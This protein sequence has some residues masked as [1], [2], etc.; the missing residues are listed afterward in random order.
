MYTGPASPRPGPGAGG[1]AA[2]MLRCACGVA[3]AHTCPT[4]HLATPRVGAGDERQ[5]ILSRS[6]DSGDHAKARLVG[7]GADPEPGRVTHTP[8]LLTASR[9]SCLSAGREAVC[10]GPM[11]LAA[12][13]PRPSFCSLAGLVVTR[14][15]RAKQNAGGSW[16]SSAMISSSIGSS[17]TRCMS[18]P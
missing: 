3:D 5:T 2:M 14:T 15:S 16:Q 7:V 10:S 1:H 4:Q 11:S 8:S 18:A 17:A 12:P 6:C 9:P 13:R